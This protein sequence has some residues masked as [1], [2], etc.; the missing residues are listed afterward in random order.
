MSELM[1][2]VRVF[3]IHIGLYLYVYF[4]ESYIEANLFGLNESVN[5]ENWCADFRCSEHQ[6]GRAPVKRACA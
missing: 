4:A 3:L 6:R 1:L 2:D 5:R